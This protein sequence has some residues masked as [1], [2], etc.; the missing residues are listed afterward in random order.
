MSLFET[1]S[2]RF[3]V[4]KH[5]LDAPARSVA[6][7]GEISRRCRQSDDPGVS[8]SGIAD[9]ADV[10][11]DALAGEG[12]GLEIGAAG[13]RERAGC[14]SCRAPAGKEIALEPQPIIPSLLS[15]P[16]DHLGGS[17]QAIGEQD[18][19]LIGGQPAGDPLAQRLLCGQ[20]RACP[21]GL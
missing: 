2:S 15:A 4:G 12:N 1:E 10:G 8:V 16:S 20:A 14:G 13:Q 19:G 5:G 3:E 6:Q 18:H 17:V 9:D 7:G 11:D 21:V